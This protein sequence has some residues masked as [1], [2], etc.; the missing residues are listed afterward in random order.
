MSG[1]EKRRKNQINIALGDAIVSENI[2]FCSFYFTVQRIRLFY[3]LSKFL[4]TVFVA[5]PFAG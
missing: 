3:L 1:S 4:F 5:S 2:S